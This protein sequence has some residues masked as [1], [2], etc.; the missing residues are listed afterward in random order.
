MG[1]EPVRNAGKTSHGSGDMGW[2]PLMVEFIHS[3]E[4]HFPVLMG[5]SQD[6]IQNAAVWIWTISGIELPGMF[7]VHCWDKGPINTIINYIYIII[8]LLFERFLIR[9]SCP[10]DNRI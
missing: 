7:S 8:N 6:A 9:N 3:A 5:Q 1:S 4:C 2:G 10:D